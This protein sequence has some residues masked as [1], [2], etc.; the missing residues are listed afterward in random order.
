[1]SNI[2]TGSIAVLLSCVYFGYYAI[3]LNSVALWIVIVGGL[4]MLVFDFVKSI[5]EGKNGNT[6]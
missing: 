4:A 3:K 1:M 6:D 5:R 2:I